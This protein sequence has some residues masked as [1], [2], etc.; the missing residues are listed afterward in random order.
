[1]S[2]EK[3]LKTEIKKHKVKK[4]VDQKGS[5]GRKLRYIT[6][7]KLCNFTAPIDLSIDHDDYVR[8]QLLESLFQ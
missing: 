6:L 2:L 7:S 8:K 4:N 3:Q 5:K 1:M